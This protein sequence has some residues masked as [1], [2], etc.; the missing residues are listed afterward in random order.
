MAIR[1]SLV[2]R[3]IEFERL[4]YIGAR[5]FLLLTFCVPKVYRYIQK[6]N[7]NVHFTNGEKTF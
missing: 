7:N 4:Y 1:S 6:K 3:V 5:L 2:T